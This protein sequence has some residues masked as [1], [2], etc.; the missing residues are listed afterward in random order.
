MAVW[1]SSFRKEYV[2]WFGSVRFGKSPVRL[3]TNFLL[4]SSQPLN[5]HHFF[6][7]N[8]TDPEGADPHPQGQGQGHADQQGEGGLL[9]SYGET[10]IINYLDIFLGVSRSIFKLVDDAK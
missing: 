2:V 1:F 9:G 8:G 3:T 10:Q 5:S 7:K 6:Q 4:S